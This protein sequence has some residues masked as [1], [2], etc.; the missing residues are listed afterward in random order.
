MRD[1]PTFR[2]FAREAI[3]HHGPGFAVGLWGIVIACMIG[4]AAS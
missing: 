4:V 2:T 1:Q 3:E